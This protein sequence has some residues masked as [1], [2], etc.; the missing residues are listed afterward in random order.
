VVDPPAAAP[1]DGA[2]NEALVE[3]LS[4]ILGC[5]RRNITVASGLRSRDKRLEIAGVT[6]AD[7]DRKLAA[8]SALAK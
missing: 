5:P 2:A 7:L 6:R 4:A 1:V 8:A 3:F